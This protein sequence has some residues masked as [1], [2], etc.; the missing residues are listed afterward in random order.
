MDFIKWFKNILVPKKI[1]I[2]WKLDFQSNVWCSGLRGYRKTFF[3]GKKKFN[4]IFIHLNPPKNLQ[5]SCAWIPHGSEM[6][7]VSAYVVFSLLF[8]YTKG[9]GAVSQEM[10]SRNKSCSDSYIPSG[11]RE[12]R[13]K[14]KTPD[15]THC[16][17]HRQ[18]LNHNLHFY[19]SK[20]SLE[21]SLQLETFTVSLMSEREKR[22]FS[23]FSFTL[24]SC[25]DSVLQLQS[26]YHFLI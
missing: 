23:Q 3:P 6:F 5:E 17:V 24:T 25:S 9:L 18:T 12:E 1:N 4:P 11:S 20:L 15:G 13:K 21:K 8:Y 14:R 26:D 22:S 7:A 10:L 16:A 2:F 19:L